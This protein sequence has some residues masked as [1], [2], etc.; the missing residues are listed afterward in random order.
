MLQHRDHNA[1]GRRLDA[2]PLP[3]DARPLDFRLMD[4]PERLARTGDRWKSAL[5]DKQDLAQALKVQR[6]T[7]H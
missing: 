4:A 1:P 2:T 5:T 6:G 7:G 3:S